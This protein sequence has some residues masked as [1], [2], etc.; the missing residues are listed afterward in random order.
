MCDFSDYFFWEKMFKGHSKIIS[1]CI[2]TENFSKN[3]KRS[4]KITIFWAPTSLLAFRLRNVKR[5]FHPCGSLFSKSCW[6]LNK[7]LKWVHVSCLRMTSELERRIRVLLSTWDP[8]SPF[9]A[10][11]K[12]VLDEVKRLEKPGPL[13]FS[14]VPSRCGLPLTNVNGRCRQYVEPK[15]IHAFGSQIEGDILDVKDEYVGK[16]S[17]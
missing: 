4:L 1:N 16:M 13:R 17:C 3:S 6:K 9:R 7:S 2:F 5:L 8:M 14:Y 10:S 15:K 11:L 12:F